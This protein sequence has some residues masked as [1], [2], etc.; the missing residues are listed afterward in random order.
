MLRD[1]ICN[2][3]EYDNSSRSVYYSSVC[4]CVCVCVQNELY[5][6]WNSNHHMANIFDFTLDELQS[7]KRSVPQSSTPKCSIP[8]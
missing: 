4:V 6:S 1:A 3:I 5:C 7:L 8:F 2:T